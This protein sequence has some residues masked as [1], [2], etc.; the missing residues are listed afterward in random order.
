MEKIWCT[1]L[2]P[3]MLVGHCTCFLLA[4]CRKLD[5]QPLNQQIMRFSQSCGMRAC[6]ACLLGLLFSCQPSSHDARPNVLFIMVDDLRDWT[7][8]S[9]AFSEVQTP[10]LDRL[11]QQGQ[12][13]LNAYCAA[14]VCAPSRTALLSGISPAHTGVYENGQLWEGDLRERETLTQ[15]FMKE[16]YHVAGFGKIYHGQGE[17]PNWHEYV[18]GDYSPLPKAYDNYYALGNP[19]DVPDS[20]TGDW[21]RV[22]NAIKVLERKVD[23]P[24][25]LAC[26]LVRPHTPWN[27]PRKYFDQYDQR[28][29]ALPEVLAQ[30][31]EDVPSIGRQIAHRIHRDQYGKSL[32]WTHQAIVDS[33]LWRPNLH[34]YLASITYADAQIGR[35]LDAWEQSPYSQNGIVVL[36]GDHGWHLGEKEHWSK[37]TLWEEATRTPLIVLAPGLTQAGA[38]CQTPVSLLDIYPTL[39]DLCGLPPRE[40]LDGTSLR[41]LLKTPTA[42]REQPAI[43]VWGQDNVGLRT[44]RWRYIQYCDGSR[45]LYDVQQDPHEWN[46]LL[47]DAPDAYADVQRQLQA[48]IPACQPPSSFRTN[49]TSW[50]EQQG[51]TPLC[52]EA[53]QP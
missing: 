48:W 20:A 53:A 33:G 51:I 2:I 42:A 5:K 25:F 40:G 10:Q 8:Y 52:A 3:G 41:E 45:E 17:G 28:E 31:L 35:L 21:K 12:V 32:A 9:T 46:N 7:A 27:V 30:D 37:R 43:T 19:L 14:P 18:H 11:A 39:M 44:S 26:G 47:H 22:T 6:W 13:F 34:A 1:A 29:L 36:M 49:R 38:R 23:S 15:A 4:I 16:G 24:L 50:F